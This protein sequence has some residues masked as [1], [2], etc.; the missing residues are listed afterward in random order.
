MND[1]EKRVKELEF[2]VDRLTDALAEHSK[3]IDTLQKFA[4][5]QLEGDEKAAM[6]RYL[7]GGENNGRNFKNA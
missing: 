6:Q 3:I 4:I 7:R 1:L 5:Q 2:I